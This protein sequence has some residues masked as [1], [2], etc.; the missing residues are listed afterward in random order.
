MHCCVWGVGPG[1]RNSQ[2]EFAQAVRPREI[3]NFAL[4]DCALE[5][6]DTVLPPS[7]SDAVAPRIKRY[8]QDR[9]GHLDPRTVGETWLP[10]LE[11]GRKWL[12][13]I[14]KNEAAW[15][16]LNEISRGGVFV[17]CLNVILWFQ[18][19]SRFRRFLKLGGLMKSRV[20]LPALLCWTWPDDCIGLDSWEL[21]GIRKS[22]QHHMTDPNCMRWIMKSATRC[23]L[24]FSNRLIF[25]PYSSAFV[26]VLVFMMQ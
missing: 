11:R 21:D 20:P 13:E 17:K 6:F 7:D 8:P 12:R 2:S 10:S 1:L 3:P 16:C 25:L 19:T 4:Q 15:C 14:E 18:Q 26:F 23:L 24:S 5:I 22:Q 9:H